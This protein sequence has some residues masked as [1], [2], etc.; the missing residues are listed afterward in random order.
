MADGR[1]VSVGETRLYNIE[2]PIMRFAK[3]INT[4]LSRKEYYTASDLLD[5]VGIDTSLV[6]REVSKKLG[7]KVSQICR[8]GSRFETQCICVQL[9]D[10]GY[11][12]M[13]WAMDHGALFCITNAKYPGIPCIVVE[14]PTEIY[15]KLCR[16]YYKDN[17]TKVVA[18]TGS[19]GKTTTK[20]M[21]ECVLSENFPTFCDPD[22]E[23]QIDCVGYMCQHFPRNAIIHVQE[24]SEDSPNHI[25]YI[26]KILQPEI[27]IITSIDQSHIEMFGSQEGITE[28]I[29]SICEGMTAANKLIIN[30]EDNNAR[31]HPAIPQKITVSIFNPNA[32]FYAGD[33]KIRKDGIEF[34]VNSSKDGRLG[35]LIVKGVYAEHN[36]LNALYAYVA[37]YLQGMTHAQIQKGIL[38]FRTNGIRQNVIRT[39]NSI[40]YA[41][42]YNA[43]AKSIKAAI[44]AAEKIPIDGKLVAVIGDVEEAGT[45][46][47]QTH[48]EIMSYI[49]NSNIDLLYAYGE[50]TCKAAERY[51]NIFRPTLK[52]YTFEDKKDIINS[53]KNMLGVGDLVI[54]KASRKSELETIIKAIWPRDYWLEEIKHVIPIIKWRVKI[55]FC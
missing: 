6:D 2:R 18:V 17:K 44:D 4:L 25:R 12:A 32:D 54:F 9:Y 23:N 41:D 13:K 38:R 28:E 24:I 5:K 10:D 39:K 21:V 3:V 51:K 14:N 35:K 37:G 11:L 27:A 50:K 43:V 30:Y 19:I 8:A 55:L 48:N 29:F 36:A 31:N 15:A 53:M 52:V 34:D 16:L 22:N 46:S 47:D 1:S 20:K 45:Y 42:C 7:Y 26:T 49:N 40:I 33:I